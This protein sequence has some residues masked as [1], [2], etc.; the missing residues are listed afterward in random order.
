A[1]SSQS[2]SLS[3]SPPQPGTGSG[4]TG[5]G[6]SAAFNSAT[7]L[8]ALAQEPS[9]ATRRGLSSLCWLSVRLWLCL[10]RC[11]WS[12]GVCIGLWRRD[13]EGVVGEGMGRWSGL[14]LVGRV[15]RGEGVGI[16]LSMRRMRI[17]LVERRTRR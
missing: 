11:R 16:V 6:N 12:W 7:G 15:L 4:G 5:T 13:L 9:I 2:P 8:R 14:I 17:S 1:C 10:R 3:P